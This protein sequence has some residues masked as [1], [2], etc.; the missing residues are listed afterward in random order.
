MGPSWTD[1]NCHNDICP[2]NICPYQEYQLLLTL[3][4]PNFKGMFL[5]PSLTDANC[6]SDI[7]TGN[8]CPP[9]EICRCSIYSLSWFLK[10]FFAY[11]IKGVHSTDS[12]DFQNVFF[13]YQIKG[14]LI[15][16][17]K[18]RLNKI[19][20]GLRFLIINVEFLGFWKL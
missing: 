7:C 2:G 9:L 12:Y 18:K 10:R 13:A 17:L 8:I 19:N 16:L 5:N 3:F 4:W 14:V 11:Q 1:F 15:C 20:L 6:H